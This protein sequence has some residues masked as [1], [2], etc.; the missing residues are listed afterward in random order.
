MYDEKKPISTDNLEIRTEELTEEE[1]Q[2]LDEVTASLEDARKKVDQIAKDM[3]ATREAMIDD[4]LNDREWMKELNEDRALDGM[5][6][7]V[8]DYSG[9]HPV[10]VSGLVEGY[11]Y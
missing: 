4:T 10:I 2:V 3:A 11:D 8:V 1:D 7:I 6:P 5:P 9:E